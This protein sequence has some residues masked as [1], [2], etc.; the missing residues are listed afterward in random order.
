MKTP[1]TPKMTQYG[2]YARWIVFDVFS[3]YQVRLVF[4]NDL[5][6]SANERVGHTP[7]GTTDAFCWHL[8]SNGLSYLFLKMDSTESTVAHECWHVIYRILMWCGVKDFDDEM[9]AYHIGHLVGKVYDFK[10]AI[11]SKGVSDDHSVNRPSNT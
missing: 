5:T 10:K 2:D 4:T 1:K 9:V 11:Q 8:K 7:G 6:K 3:D